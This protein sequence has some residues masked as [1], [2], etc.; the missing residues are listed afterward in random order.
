MSENPDLIP[1]VNPIPISVLAVFFAIAGLEA[2]FA[3]GQAGL[4]G[5]PEA[6]GWRISWVRELGF[7][8]SILTEMWQKGLWPLEHVKRLIT[9]AFVHQSFTHSLFAM[10]LL[11]ALG[12]MVAERLG[13]LAFLVLFFGSVIGGALIY[14][15]LTG[16]KS[17]WLTGAYPGVYGLIGGYSFVMWRV[18]GAKGLSQTP[19]FSL[20]AM[21]MGVQLLFSIFMTIGNSWIADL[22]GFFVGFALCFV[23][24]PGEWAHLLRRLRGE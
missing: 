4:V 11:L 24:A 8:G 14:A 10:V 20:I 16:A 6:I 23:V 13:S 2:T 17:E 5:G 7:H 1:P 3:L 12:K 15:A 19:A 21:L 9:Y 22:A 18:L